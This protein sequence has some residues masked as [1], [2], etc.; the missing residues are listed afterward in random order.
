MTAT[1]HTHA[2]ATDE[3]SAQHARAMDLLMR[4]QSAVCDL[5]APD[6]EF[7]TITWGHVGSL[8]EL[9]RQLDNALAFIEGT[10]A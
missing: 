9:N 2:S 7:V 5:P 6:T 4:L 10:D 8:G 1:Q 3:Y